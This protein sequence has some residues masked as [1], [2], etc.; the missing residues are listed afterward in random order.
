VTSVAAT[1]RR[2]QPVDHG[3]RLLGLRTLEAFSSQFRSDPSR[4]APPVLPG[5]VEP[6]VRIARQLPL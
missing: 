3:G 1:R 5:T 2:D 6:T 4:K